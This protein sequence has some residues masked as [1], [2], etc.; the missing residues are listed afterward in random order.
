MASAGEGGQKG[1]DFE[2]FC[3]GF[4]CYSSILVHK[5]QLLRQSSQDLNCNPVNF[6][7]FMP[8]MPQL[9]DISFWIKQLGHL[10]I[11]LSSTVSDKYIMLNGVSGNFC[12]HFANEADD[13]N[14]YFSQSWSSNTKNFILVGSENV[15][16]FN[17]NK[18]VK[19]ET[20]RVNSIKENLDKFYQYLVAKSYKSDKDV[21]PFLI[22]IFRQFRT[23]TA[24]VNNPVQ[25]LN[26]LFVLLASLED[27]IETLDNGKWGISEQPVIRG[28]EAYVDRF[29]NGIGTI[30]PDL[31]LIL[32]H[33]AGALFQEAQKEVVFFNTQRD[34]FGTFSGSLVTK[35]ILY[36]SIHYTPSYLARSIVENALRLL[37]INEVPKLNILDPACGSAEFLIEVLR[38][39]KEKDYQGQIVIKGYDTSETAVNT[40]LFLL[41]YEKR[42]VWQ[43]RL[44]F[45][46][47]VVTDS[48]MEDWNEE[49]SLILMNPPF[50]S[51][52][53][54]KDVNRD[55]VRTTLDTNFKGKPNQ[56]SA[57]FF[58][59]ITH[60]RP[61]G[62]LGSVVPS[63]F[64]TMD[65][66]Q[67][68]RNTVE[69]VFTIDL[70]GKL[71]NF[72]FED[73]LTD[74]SIIVGK[75]PKEGNAVPTLLWT[76]NEKGTV[77][78]ALR[79]LRRLQYSNEVT[80]DRLDFSIFKP[81]VFPLITDSWKPVSLKEH[82]LIL[83][84]KRYVALGKLA[85]IG[86]VF[87]VQQGIRTGNN[88]VF[89]ITE[90]EYFELPVQ[91]RKYFRW[92]VENESIKNGVL[93][94]G[95][96]IWFPYD[97][98][99]LI[100]SEEDELSRN[101]NIYYNQYLLPNK[102]ALENRAGITLWWELT[103][104]R[105][106]QFKKSKKL[107]ST[108][109]GDSSSF[110]IDFNGEYVVERGYAWQTKKKFDKDDYYFYLS[111]FSSPFFDRLL[112]I[113]SKELAG[114]KW[115]DL[116]KSKTKNIPIPNVHDN[117]I[118]NTKDYSKM[119]ELGRRLAKGDSYVKSLLNDALFI[120]YPSGLL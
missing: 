109:F 110:A 98:N 41:T 69:E 30:V 59:A 95:G 99:G 64:F 78:D 38:Q 92:V 101:C 8:I 120:Y 113:F 85:I 106:W 82:D 93:K 52:E 71:G 97:N 20:I 87:D 37:P 25:A 114:G 3:G 86:D 81:A 46:I 39:L 45:N 117:A 80:K 108:E 58:K 115:Y 27:T 89:K 48:L 23:H 54:L 53:L 66:Y 40:S 22:D 91:E 111:L 32:R 11:H 63:S 100:I 49:Y 90:Q 70:I 61:D 76:R 7:I 103:R 4:G 29:R 88:D 28:F 96:Y 9:T 31:N 34:L 43:D 18:D 94:N 26:L 1:T 21:V 13:K 68:L 14:T 60:L 19:E 73:A 35:D 77:H 5:R 102:I 105:N 51:W 44:T 17:W 16:L 72:V 84:L 33:S 67:K 55:A 112:S 83:D 62:V 118:K 65:A 107:I 12:L 56:A 79:E 119:V 36:S 15:K 104:P 74:A 2:L 47:N 42:T 116:G 57:F 50:V 10:P 75:K 6:Y 24:E